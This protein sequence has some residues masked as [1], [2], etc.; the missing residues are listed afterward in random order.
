MREPL[1]KDLLFALILSLLISLTGWNIYKV[2]KRPIVVINYGDD[3]VRERTGK[4]QTSRQ[5]LMRRISA[6][7]PTT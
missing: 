6:I 4:A 1:N 2:V 7:E 3:W 5:C